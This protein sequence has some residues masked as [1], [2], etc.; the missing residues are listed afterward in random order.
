MEA[1]AVPSQ[2][3]PHIDAL[4]SE[5]QGWLQAW[6]RRKLG[7]S[8]RAADL[9]HDTFLRL[10]TSRMPAD[11]DEPR[12]YL[13]TVARNV[14]LNHQRRQ[15]LE[16]AWL[17]ELALVPEALVPSEEDRA[18]MLET[19]LAISVLLD[20][21]SIK[22]RRAFLLSQLDGLTYAEIAA[23]LG[24]SASRVRQ[25]MADALTRCYAAL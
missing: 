13:S 9:A 1:A 12:A 5:H 20:G 7:C 8:H 3:Y 16:Q 17:A 22:A 23:E 21:L 6:L 10:L 18:I 4:Y 25:Y 15:K 11:L 24:V 2:P 19:L 14:L